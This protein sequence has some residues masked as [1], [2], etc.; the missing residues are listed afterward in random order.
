MQILQRKVP[1]S[2]KAKERAAEVLLQGVQEISA[3]IFWGGDFEQ[4]KQLM[5]SYQLQESEIKFF[6]G[7]SGWTPDQLDGELRDNAWIVTDKFETQTLFSNTEEVNLWK[8][9]VINLGQ[10]YAHIANFPE[11]PELN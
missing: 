6:T 10:R 7:Y 1:K 3:G 5:S 2:R 11:N 8:Q 4:V 9:A